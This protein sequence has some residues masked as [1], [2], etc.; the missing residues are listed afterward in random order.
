MK[1]V[2]VTHA[3][4]TNRPPKRLS[5]AGRW[6]VEQVVDMIRGEMGPGYRITRAVS[7]SAARC[8]ETAILCLEELGADDLARIETDERLARLDSPDKLEGVLREKAQD[9]LAVFCHADLGGVLPAKLDKD[10]VKDGWFTRKP[11][12]VVMDWEPG[13]KWEHSRVVAVK[14]VPEEISLMAA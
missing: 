5:L 14:T 11:V 13:E 1:V 7:S 3:K 4:T 2:F 9:G 10:A 6:E 12:L 8:L